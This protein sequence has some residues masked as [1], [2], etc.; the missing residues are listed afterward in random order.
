MRTGFFFYEQ[1]YARIR[2]LGKEPNVKFGQ[3]KPVVLPKG[4]EDRTY[5]KNT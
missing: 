3:I 4:C 2:E 5:I 1:E